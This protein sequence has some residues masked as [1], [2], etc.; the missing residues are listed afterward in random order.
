MFTKFK[1]Q[2]SAKL[3]EKKNQIGNLVTKK[4]EIVEDNISD[5][6]QAPEEKLTQ[7]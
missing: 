7:V 2:V 3:E 4:A 6:R 1:T 5:G